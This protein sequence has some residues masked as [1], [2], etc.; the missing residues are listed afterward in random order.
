M[1][2]KEEKQLNLSPKYISLKKTELILEQMKTKVCQ[3]NSDNI[4]KGTGFFCKIPFPGDNRLLSVLITNNHILDE[5]LLNQK[6]KKISLTINNKDKEIELDNRI[7]YTNKKYDITII[8]LKTED[9]IHNFFE[10]DNNISNKSNLSYFGKSIYLLHYPE[11]EESYVSYGIIKGLE[12]DQNYYEFNHVCSTNFG[13]SG[14]PILDLSNNTIIGVHKA[15]NNKEPYNIGLFLKY[16]L[17]EF[18]NKY[19]SKDSIINFKTKVNNRKNVHFKPNDINSITDMKKN[20]NQINFND[21]KPINIKLLN[22]GD[23]SYLNSVLYLLGNIN[24]FIYFFLSQSNIKFLNSNIMSKPLSFIFVRLFSHFYSNNGE[25]EYKPEFLKKVLAKLNIVYE[26]SKRENPNELLSFIIDRLHSELNNKKEG[27]NNI[28]D[29]NLY[30]KND[31][32]KNGINNF[33]NSNYS[34]IARIFSWFE[35]KE[36]K[37]GQCYNN[38]YNFYTF[39]TFELDIIGTYKYKNSFN[40]R[41]AVTLYECIQ[42]QQFNKNNI[43][44][45]CNKCKKF[46]LFQNCYKIFS[47]PNKFIF[48]I[49]RGDLDNNLLNIP[50]KIEEKIDLTFHVENKQ[51]F[52]NYELSGI[53][54][55]SN[56]P[57]N[58]QYVSFCKSPMDNKWYFYDV[59]NITTYE[60]NDIIIFHNDN[61]KYIPLILL[62]NNIKNNNDY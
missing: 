58:Y 2:I 57:Q 25:E 4:V 50:F 5:S 48:S 44:L 11:N 40:N 6:K 22:L 52:T 38:I 59:E 29:I 37:C 55:V 16:P 54:S 23:T 8:E 26:K 53:L 10:L 39:N 61:N 60:L 21:L 15:A 14:G 13:S 47:S 51:S 3:I 31:V 17:N 35:I 32:I 20:I 1:E 42:F 36:S 18:I 7:K 27:N 46:T 9:R 41:S 12:R 34:I 30:D 45:Y 19:K 28:N 62:Y 43:K 33:L 56:N 49:N 24:D